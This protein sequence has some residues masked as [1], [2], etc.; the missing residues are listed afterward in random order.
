[1]LRFVGASDPLGRWKARE[2]LARQ[3]RVVRHTKAWVDDSELCLEVECVLSD[4]ETVLV[5]M[6]YC[7]SACGG[8]AEWETTPYY[9][10]KV[11]ELLLNNRWLDFYRWVQ[12]Q[13]DRALHEQASNDFFAE[14]DEPGSPQ[15]EAE[16]GAEADSG[17]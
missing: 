9:F 8:A 13:F 1:M 6:H 17:S 5:E 16:P 12:A 2:L 7:W 11:V 14:F 4:G 15:S 3:P 10:M